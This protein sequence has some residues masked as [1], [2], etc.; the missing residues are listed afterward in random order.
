[1]CRDY[2]AG[3]TIDHELDEGDLAAGRKIYCLGAR[4]VG[5]AGRGGCWF[6]VLDTWR[7]WADDVRGFAIDAGHFLPEERPEEVAEALRAFFPE[8]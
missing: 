4:L 3:A 1:M 8:S 5:G 2:R 7:R 6:D